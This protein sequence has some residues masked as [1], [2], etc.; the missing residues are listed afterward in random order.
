MQAW[1][2]LSPKSLDLIPSSPRAQE[3]TLESHHHN[4]GISPAH[5]AEASP[6]VQQN[7][8]QA[9][10]QDTHYTPGPDHTTAQLLLSP[11]LPSTPTPTMQLPS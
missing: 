4:D 10:L 2:A 9:L 11:P 3:F 7:L 5:R 6:G 1:P 8:E